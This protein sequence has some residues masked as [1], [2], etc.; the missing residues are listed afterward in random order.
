MSPFTPL[1]LPNGAL[2]SITSRRRRWK[3][4]GLIRSTFHQRICS[5]SIKPGPAD[6][7]GFILDE[8]LH[9]GIAAIGTGIQVRRLLL[10]NLYKRI[11]KSARSLIVTFAPRLGELY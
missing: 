8:A 5:A 4:T 11:V 9:I 6:I 2:I 1:A 3:K 7:P 10:S